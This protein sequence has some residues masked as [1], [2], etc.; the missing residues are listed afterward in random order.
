M[1]DSGFPKRTGSLVPRSKYLAVV[2][3]RLDAYRSEL[4]RVIARP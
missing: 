2:A 4:E 1:G 3:D